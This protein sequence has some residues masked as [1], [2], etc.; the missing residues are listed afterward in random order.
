ML[1]PCGVE[2]L[3]KDIWETDSKTGKKRPKS[4][5]TKNELFREML[6]ECI[7]KMHF[8]YVLADSWF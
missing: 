7:H 2:F 5:K 3:K 1:L 8:D 6:R 4:S